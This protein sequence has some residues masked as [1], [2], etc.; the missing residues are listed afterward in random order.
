MTEMAVNTTE[1]IQSFA[2][3]DEKQCAWS[4]SAVIEVNGNSDQ[5]RSKVIQIDPA[6]FYGL[7]SII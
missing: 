3:S 2:I 1:G 6:S 5:S 7:L 4:S